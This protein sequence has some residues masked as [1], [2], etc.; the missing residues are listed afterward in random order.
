MNGFQRKMKQFVILAILFLF[1]GLIAVVLMW[2]EQDPCT[3]GAKDPGEVGVD[4]GG[5][6]PKACPLPE[7]PDGVEDVEVNWSTF[8]Q[9]GANAYDL[10]A[11]L[12]NDNESWGVSSVD[13]AFTYFDASGNELGRK[14]GKTSLMP[15]GNTGNSSQ[16]YVIEQNV[17]SNVAP[18][19]VDFKLS[20][21]VWQEVEGAVDVANL[22]EGVIAI[23]GK[24][25][26]VDKVNKYYMASGVTQNKSK[27]DFVYVN[28]AVVVYGEDNK[29]LSARKTNQKTMA[30]GDGWA[31]FVPFPNLKVAESD[32]AWVDYR[33]TTD[34]FDQNNFM[35]EYRSAQ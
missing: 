14:I 1:F 35:K 9:D 10:V 26:S 18:A 30:A 2:P 19:K 34:V 8:V 7:R 12:S 5:F 15:K 25:F 24:D 33:A 13:Y 4:C 28:I 16:Q 27:Y 21:F 6:C 20:H 3:N 29:V 22:N 11:S 31:F 23:N 32:I 17:I